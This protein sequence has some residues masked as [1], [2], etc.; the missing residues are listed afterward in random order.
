M[1]GSG[2]QVRCLASTRIIEQ[3]W[4]E[5]GPKE[6]GERHNGQS[7]GDRTA[8]RD[9]RED[10]S[11][12]VSS[13]DKEDSAEGSRATSRAPSSQ[14]QEN[15]S[16][17]ESES[18]STDGREHSNTRPEELSPDAQVYV[19]CIQEA[20]LSPDGTCIFT[21]DYDR[22]F[23]VYPIDANCK[24]KDSARPLKPYAQF[25]S[26]DPIWSFASNPLFDINESST[27]HVLVS[28]RD[29]YIALHNALWNITSTEATNQPVDISHPVASYK[30]I[31]A[32]T[33]AVIA[34]LSLTYS[35]D[36]AHF[37]A[38]TRNK[39]HIF[40]LDYPDE[41]THT[42]TTIPSSRN[43][44]KGGGRGFKGWISALSLSP[45]TTF[46]GGGLLAAGARTRHVGIYDAVSGAEVTT[47]S[48]PGTVDGRKLVN[49]NMQHIIG[50]GVSSVKYS[51]CGKYLYVA[52][53]M[54]DVLLIYDVRNFSLS[55][56]Y[57]AGRKALTK[58]KLGFD[59]WNAGASPYDIEATSHEIWAGGTDGV[60]RVWRDPYMKEGAVEAD[61]LVKAGSGDVPVVGTMVH[62][63]G[64]LAV[65]ACGMIGVGDEGLNGRRRGGGTIPRYKEWGNLDILGLS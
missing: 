32:L 22:S 54:S 41:P 57:C 53:R 18:A 31:D 24:S 44:L 42:I 8:S 3:I 9:T 64:G 59:V 17:G 23:S 15:G 37:F 20:Q 50:D 27:T 13:N 49:A 28:R 61:E 19:S 29:R 60:V 11:P 65:T 25:T 46:A 10:R 16:D 63:S 48:L 7:S 51:P 33:E 26:A 35:H 14:D 45:S 47:F 39:I 21:S 43:K 1:N 62:M 52:E 4:P 36:G 58:Q 12:R 40:D 30:V 6:A 38:G 5:E 56:G 55:L 2:L 34:P